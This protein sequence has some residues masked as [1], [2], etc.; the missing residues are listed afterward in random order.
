MQLKALSRRHPQRS[1]PELIADIQVVEELPGIDF[2]AGNSCPDH[3][4][5][6]FSLGRSVCIFGFASVAV[7]LLIHTVIFDQMF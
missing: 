7:I 3:E 1:V 4:N 2:S 6:L 5:I